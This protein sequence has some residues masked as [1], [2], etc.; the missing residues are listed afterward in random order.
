MQVPWSQHPH[1]SVK[2]YQ[3]WR[4]VK[5]AGQ[6]QED[7]PQ[8]LTTINRDP[9]ATSYSYTDY[10]HTVTDGYTH[11]LVSYDVRSYFSVNQTYSDPNWVSVFARQSITPKFADGQSKTFAQTSLPTV[12]AVS[13]YPNPFNPATTISNQVVEDA[14]VVLEVFDIMGR[15]VAAL[16]NEEKSAGYYSVRWKGRDALNNP[17]SSGVYLY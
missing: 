15:R 13:S 11:D 4:K 17:L 7:P 5:R 2:Q 10:S 14:H 16:V 9:N 3:I 1:T 6:Q 12:Y 8:I